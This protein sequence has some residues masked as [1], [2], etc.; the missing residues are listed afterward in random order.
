[1]G[2]W[3]R[4]TEA[5][6]AAGRPLVRTRYLFDI[7]R[8]IVAIAHGNANRFTASPK[9]LNDFLSRQFRLKR[10]RRASHR[11]PPQ[12]VVPQKLY[13]TSSTEPNARRHITLLSP[14]R[15]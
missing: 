10:S 6:C 12:Y 15:A 1:M 2:F 14:L 3:R 13:C 8:D 11:T 4:W 9:S 7:L 5:Q